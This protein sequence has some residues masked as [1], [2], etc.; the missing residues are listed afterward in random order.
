MNNKTIISYRKDGKI[1]IEMPEDLL[2][3]AAENNDYYNLKVFDKEL[4]LN[5]IANNLVSETGFN[6]ETGLSGFEELL[7]NMFVEA[8]EYGDCGVSMEDLEDPQY[9]EFL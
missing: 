3:F 7:D 6:G 2:I 5:Y 1:I 4:F 9:Y 8:G